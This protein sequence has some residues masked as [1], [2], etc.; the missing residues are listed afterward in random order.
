MNAVAVP[1]GVRLNNPCCLEHRHGDPSVL[2]AGE[3]PDGNN[4]YRCFIDPEH[5]F[6]A[7]V[8]LL[9]AYQ[10]DDGIRTIGEAIARFS[11]RADGNPTQRYAANVAAACGVSVDQ[12]V[13]FESLWPEILRAMSTQECGPGRFTDEQIHAG[14]ALAESE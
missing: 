3:L 11:P 5:G 14:I 12:V 7:T 4:V 8:E 2:Y 13:F 9:R 1:I 10:K 6:R